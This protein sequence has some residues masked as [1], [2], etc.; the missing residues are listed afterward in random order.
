MMKVKMRL[1]NEWFHR[2]ICWPE[3]GMGYQTVDIHLKGGRT[4]EKI[5]VIN[6]EHFEV[7][8]EDVFDVG[9]IEDISLYY[10]EG[11]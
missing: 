2:L 9:E 11:S 7:E 8:E 4:L 3:T 1:P 10:K 5:N 6:A